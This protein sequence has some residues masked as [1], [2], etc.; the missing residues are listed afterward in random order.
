MYAALKHLHVFTVVVSLSLFLLRGWWRFT[1]PE[2]LNTRWIRITPHSNDTLL[3]AAAIG[4]LVVGEFNPLENPWLIG[5]ITLLLAYISLGSIALKRSSKTAFIAAL[6][7]FGWIVFIAV[8][9][10]ILPL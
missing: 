2:R 5:K 1:A 10:Q 3:L 4:M 7:C 8:T 9:K 6:A